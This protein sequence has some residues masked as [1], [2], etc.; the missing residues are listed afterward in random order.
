MS[1]VICQQLSKSFSNGHQALR[2]ISFEITPGQFVCIVGRSGAGKS[3]LMRCLNGSLPLSGGRARIGD[4]EIGDLDGRTR[5]RLQRSVGFIYQEFYLVGRLSALQNVLTGRLGYTATWKALMGYF[6]RRDREAALQALER[7]NMLH[8]AQQRAD[9]LSGG[10]KQRVAIARAFAQG[11]RLLLC[12]EPVA[13]L[14]PELADGVLTDL[15]REAKNA[16]VTT[17]VNIHN[18]VQARQFADRIIGIAQGRVVF[19]G[20][21]GAFDVEAAD[22]VYR[23]DRIPTPVA[24]MPVPSTL[25]DLDDLLRDEDRSALA[26]MSH[27]RG[28]S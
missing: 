5:Q 27:D 4:I 14:D 10:E 22:R 18:V 21:P 24:A 25:A 1:S 26:G 23:F 7:V 16:G 8:K 3:T 13:N 15:R 17:L 12:D 20:P 19:D 6:P 9:S 28:G 2:D 11:P